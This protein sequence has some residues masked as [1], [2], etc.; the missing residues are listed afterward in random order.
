[1][2]EWQSR[3]TQSAAENFERL[4]KMAPKEFIELAR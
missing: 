1:M 3:C 4:L 2:A